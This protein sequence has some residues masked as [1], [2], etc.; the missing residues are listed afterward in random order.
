V[1]AATKLQ[2]E[3]LC[4]CFA[5]EHAGVSVTALRYHNVYGPRMP[6]NTPYA[7]VA[8]IFRSAL[9]RGEAPRVYEDGRQFRD[10]VHVRDIAD[11][12]VAALTV[13]AP[14]DGPVNVASGTPHSVHDMAAE[15][16]RAFGAGAP[17]PAVVGG[18]RL[19]DVRHVFAS[20]NRA[21]AVLGFRA[22]I[23]F[24]DGM[25]EFAYAPLRPG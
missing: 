14:F 8:S 22:S 4:R 18:Y 1:Y 21:R 24:E 19:G 10:F 5:R 12:N 6:R 16:A 13:P 3:Y 2:Q 9:E 23:S 17:R 15:L 20:P 11:A 7:G 25:R